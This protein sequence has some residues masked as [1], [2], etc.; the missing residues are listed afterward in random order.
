MQPLVIILYEVIVVLNGERVPYESM[1][2]EVLPSNGCLLYSPVASACSSRNMGIDEA[3]G[4][5]IC[6]IDD[7]DRISPTY[8]EELLGSPIDLVQ[9]HRNLRP[10]FRKQ[11]E[12]DGVPVF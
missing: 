1:L 7:D 11:I 10:F 8:L 6:F 12:N 5:Y 4:E 2:R 9:E 3:K